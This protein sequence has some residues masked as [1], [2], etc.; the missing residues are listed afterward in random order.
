MGHNLQSEKHPTI[1]I[2]LSGSRSQSIESMRSGVLDFEVQIPETMTVI[3]FKTFSIDTE[4][5]QMCQLV[6][7]FTLGALGVVS[8]HSHLESTHGCFCCLDLSQ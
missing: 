3:Y 5:V 7:A 8:W 2:P 6:S 4:T 1:V